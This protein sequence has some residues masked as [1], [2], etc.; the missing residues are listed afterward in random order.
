MSS[1]KIC[2]TI[3]GS[4][5]SKVES[6]ESVLFHF[7]GSFFIGNLHVKTSPVVVSAAQ[8]VSPHDIIV[9]ESRG[10]GRRIHGS[11]EDTKLSTNKQHTLSLCLALDR[12]NW[13]D[14]YS[15]PGQL[16]TKHMMLHI[17][18]SYRRELARLGD[19][20]PSNKSFRSNDLPCWLEGEST[21]WVHW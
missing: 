14:I 10:L 8:W 18:S 2:S 13:Q 9:M 15:N 17:P 6:S 1:T 20:H 3:W 21:V 16:L 4:R 12:C 11:V 5:T 7:G 19:S